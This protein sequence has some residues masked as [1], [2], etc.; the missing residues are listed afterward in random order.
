MA[1]QTDYRYVLEQVAA[2]LRE[3]AEALR[4]VNVYEE[5]RLMGYY[6][7]LAEILN[8]AQVAGI[9]SSDIGLAGFNPDSLLNTRKAA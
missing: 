6:E 3:R 9:E 1:T 5:G 8:Q 2:E 7:V 4:P